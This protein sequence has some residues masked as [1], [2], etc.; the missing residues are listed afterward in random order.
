MTRKLHH[1]FQFFVILT[2]FLLMAAPGFVS[3]AEKPNVLFILTDDLGWGDLGVFYQNQRSESR[4][5]ATPNLDRFAHEGVQLRE[6][7]CPAP[8]CAPSRASLLSGRHQGHE[9]IRDNQFDKALATS[10]NLGSVMKQAGY[11][12]VMVGKYG[13]PG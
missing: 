7:Y 9:P 1:V 13:L 6:H 2:G 3:A 10:H 4:K 5:H 8:V 12:T 11:G